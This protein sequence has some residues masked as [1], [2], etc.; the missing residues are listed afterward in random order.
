MKI[1]EKSVVGIDYTLKNDNGEVLDSSQGRE[2]LYYLQGFG[3]IIP[4]LEEALLDKEVGDSIQVSIPPEKA[5]GPRN[6]EA[7]VQV[8]RDQFEGVDDIQVGMEVQTQGEQ[9]IQLFTVS[10]IFGDTIMLDGNHPLAGETLHFDVK[11]TDVREASEEELAHGH[12]HG[13]GGHHH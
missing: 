1:A 6:E 9:G 10:K 13:P 12:V 2:P 5:Y 4:G 11:V 7:V 3:N 8:S